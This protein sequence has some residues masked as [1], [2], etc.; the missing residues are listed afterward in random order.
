MADPSIPPADGRCILLDLPTEILSMMSKVIPLMSLVPFLSAHPALLSLTRTTGLTPL[1]DAVRAALHRQGHYPRALAVLPHLSIFL[2]PDPKPL[3]LSILTQA[4]ADWLGSHFEPA[5]WDDGLWQ[6]AF[7]MRFLPSWRAPQPMG[8]RER[9]GQKAEGSYCSWR[10]DFY[11]NLRRVS[12]CSLDHDKRFTKKSTCVVLESSGEARALHT[13]RHSSRRG[14]YLAFDD[15]K[16]AHGLS[17]YPT[18]V[19]E[20]VRLQ[21]VRLLLI[22]VL[23]DEHPQ[24][25]NV[26]AHQALH[27]PMLRHL[28]EILPEDLPPV[29]DNNVSQMKVV[30]D[31]ACPYPDLWGDDNG[32][33]SIPMAEF[34][35]QTMKRKRWIG[36]AILTVWRDVADGRTLP[37]PPGTWF[38]EGE[39][40]NGRGELREMTFGLEDLAVLLPWLRVWEDN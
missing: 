26:N 21:D 25:V 15:L 27:S 10:M 11:R 8:P 38:V 31:A 16:E 34:D 29:D 28:T 24:L 12:G 2:P 35:L 5:L 40:F 30:D 37:G 18:A 36:P 33:G 22:G 20:V 32:E 3:L 39:G 14:A 17:S 13:R 9:P 4:K 1:P 6:E 23:S 7:Q 19:R